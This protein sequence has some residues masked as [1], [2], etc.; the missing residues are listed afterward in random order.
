[1]PVKRSHFG[2]RGLVHKEWQREVGQMPLWCPLSWIEF[3]QWLLIC[4]LSQVWLP[5]AVSALLPGDSMTP[6]G[7]NLCVF[8]TKELTEPFLPLVFTFL[9]SSVHLLHFCQR[10]LS[11]HQI[12][13]QE[14]QSESLHRLPPWLAVGCFPGEGH[15]SYHEP[16]ASCSQ[17]LPFPFMLFCWCMSPP[18]CIL[19]RKCWCI[20][21]A[22]MS[23][24][25]VTFLGSFRTHECLSFGF[26]SPCSSLFHSPFHIVLNWFFM[27]PTADLGMC[28]WTC[29]PV[30][31]E[32]S[33]GGGWHR[34]AS[35][36]S[37]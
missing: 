25:R 24:R 16:S 6:N 5:Q 21:T 30:P 29:V 36:D 33:P 17:R 11:R 35:P 2:W 14:M 13:V 23:T 4:R 3:P 9:P 31:T 1:M 8:Q 7:D 18:P 27:S 37:Y 22:L 32:A 20:L 34:S 19:P 15:T 28:T 12:F 10:G 26:Y